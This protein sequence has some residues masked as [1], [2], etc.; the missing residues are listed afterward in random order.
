MLFHYNRFDAFICNGFIV[1]VGFFSSEVL[2]LEFGCSR[3]GPYCSFY[4]AL[5]WMNFHLNVHVVSRKLELI[6]QCA[7]RAH[8]HIIMTVLRRF[9]LDLDFLIAQGTE[10]SLLDLLILDLNKIDIDLVSLSLF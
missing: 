6:Y 2:W 5:R 7:T 4:Y 3:R 10:K 9:K 1:R 8:M